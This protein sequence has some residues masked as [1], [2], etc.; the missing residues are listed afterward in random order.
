MPRYLKA[1][2]AFGVLLA[3]CQPSTSP[4]E[5]STID[6][7][8]ST[9][10][11][12]ADEGRDLIV[13][14]MIEGSVAVHDATGAEVSR[15]DPPPGS[16][17][18]QPTWLDGATIVFSEVSETGS[19]SL[20][21]AHAETGEIV[22]RSAMDTPPFY[23]SPAPPGGTHATTSLRNDPSGA[24]LIAE[25]ID[26][27]GNASMLS[28]ESPFYTSWSLG[29]DSLAMHIV[30]QRLDIWTPD[31]TATI[32]AGAALFQTP[33]WVEKGLVALRIVDDSQRLT[34]WNSG[35]F[36]DLATVDGPAGFVA[37][38]DLV[39]IQAT[40]RPDAGSIAAGLRTQTIL[41]IP[42]GKLVVLDAGKGTLHTVSNELALLYQWSQSGESLLYATLADEPLSLEWH[43]WSAAETATT[44]AFVLQPPWFQNL[45]PFFDQYAQSV[46]LWSSS[47]DYI[48]YPA[49]VDG[50]PVVLIESIDGSDLTTISGGTWA[51]WAPSG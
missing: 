23:F 32:A 48:G 10:Q 20:T 29:G 37:S 26:D 1:L 43:I 17:F 9:T 30:G 35:S 40:E 5:T 14:S 8:P 11:P 33:V 2:I 42:A 44:D 19:H 12:G 22:W 18:R 47:D 15:I 7:V 21:A 13:V 34:V 28:D 49:V 36:S 51:A 6:V 3:A 45:V 25:L 16:I 46:L 38:G 24:G 39:A 41:T 50:E 27:G 31:E 4:V